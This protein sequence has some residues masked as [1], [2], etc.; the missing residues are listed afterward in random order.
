VAPRSIVL[1]KAAYEKTMRG[2][3]ARLTISLQNLFPLDSGPRGSEANEESLAKLRRTRAV[4]GEVAARL[5]LIRPPRAVRTEHDK[6]VRGIAELE[7]ELDRLLTG[8]QK[9]SPNSFASL[10]RFRS[11]RVIASATTAIRNK[12]YAIG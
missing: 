10:M 7:T 9:G 12:G 2:L 11:T 1:G 5:T 3:G 6:L 4:A 8:I